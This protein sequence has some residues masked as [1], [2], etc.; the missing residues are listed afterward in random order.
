MYM[1][2]F[3]PC[4]ITCY[5]YVH[6]YVYLYLYLLQMPIITV[7]RQFAVKYM[8]IADCGF[9]VMQFRYVIGEI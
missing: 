4:E 8:Y 7:N 6:S 5:W 9:V 1:H 2:S 3:T